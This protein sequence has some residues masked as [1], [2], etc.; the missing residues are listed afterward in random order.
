MLGCRR[1]LVT[2]AQVTE[3]AKEETVEVGVSEVES[4]VEG[5]DAGLGQAKDVVMVIVAAVTGG[6]VDRRGEVDCRGHRHGHLLADPVA[7][8]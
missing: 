4:D 5:T 3:N 2:K 1:I 7:C 8:R 6:L